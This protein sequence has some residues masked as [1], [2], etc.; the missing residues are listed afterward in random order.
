MSRSGLFS[1]LSRTLGIA[2]WCDDQG[3][4]TQ[5]GVPEARALEQ[6]A[7]ISRRELLAGMAAVG[8]IAGLP[9]FARAN[10]KRVGSD[11]AIVG[12]GLAGLACADRLATRGV[13]A[14]LYE[15][16][17][18]VGGRCWSLRGFFPGQVAERGGELIDNLHKTMLGYAST[19]KI[20]KETQFPKSAGE[21]AYFFGG[22]HHH[23]AA[24]VEEYRAL[25][26]AMRAD[27]QRISGA[28]TADSYNAADLE[29]DRMNIAEYLQT[30]GAGPLITAALG[31]AYLAEYGL[32][33]EE[34]S[35]LNLLLFVKIDRRSRFMPF[36]VFSDERY[37]F[38]DGNDA[39][40]QGLA[41]RLP[42]PVEHGLQLVRVRKT[43]GERVE[44]TFKQGNTTVTKAHDAV[45]LA[46]PFSVLRGVELDASLGL[47]PWKRQ[48]ID[49]LGYGTNAK[50]MVGFNGPFWAAQGY[51]GAS[52]SDLLNHQATWETNPSRATSSNAI[53]TDYASGHRGANLNH[54]N[55]QLEAG[56]FVTAL[57]KVYPGAL[58]NATRV[59]GKYVA[60]L[61]HWPS[62]PLSLGSYTC[63]RP[64]Q[65][66]TICGN[67]GKAV[68]NLHFAG[69]HANSFYVWQGFMEGAALSGIDAANALL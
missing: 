12:A 67:E 14:S 49:Q 64:G 39:I 61:E 45:V 2:R 36:G 35:A 44:L 51:N 18:R 5:D 41:S 54:R 38:T 21:E 4:P 56:K 60:H 3:L 25:T 59:G 17:D 69:E 10:G 32:E 29:L 34:Q 9:R 24:I 37:H 16:S 68:G 6:R 27:M 47:P 26:A 13:A 53:L 43:S 28:P 50:M 15:A 66:T 7:M 62:N 20:A 22:V 55:V 40:A 46:I 57:D 11:I 8:A 1:R 19:F 23:E 33:L 65:F 52:Y 63:Y 31:E 58:A 48:A 30:R 42:R